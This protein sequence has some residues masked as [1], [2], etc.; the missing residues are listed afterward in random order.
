MEACTFLKTCKTAMNKINTSSS[1]VNYEFGLLDKVE[2]VPAFILV[3]LIFLLRLQ[4][5]V[6]IL[7]TLLL[8]KCWCF[9]I[10]FAGLSTSL[11]VIFWKAKYYSLPPSP[12]MIIAGQY[13]SN[14]IDRQYLLGDYFVGNHCSKIFVAR[15]FHLTE[16]F[17][18]R[19]TN[20]ELSSTTF[21]EGISVSWFHL[22]GKLKR[23]KHFSFHITKK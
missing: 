9:K 23:I 3:F 4:L 1:G 14:K 16:A 6:L 12:R 5:C 15:F 8:I 11:A 2:R 17:G 10:Q 22:I 20:S 21:L 13:L 19:S 7:Q 18:P